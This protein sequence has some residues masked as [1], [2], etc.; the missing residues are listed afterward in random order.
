[1]SANVEQ[2]VAHLSASQGRLMAYIFSLV[3]KLQDAQDVFQQTSLVL[4]RKYDQF[5]SS[6]DFLTWACGVASY[7]V[8]NYQRAASRDR[9][10]FNDALLQTLADER[11]AGET[12]SQQR[13]LALE[14]CVKR[15]RA[16][17]RELIEKA[18]SGQ[19]ALP[20]LA[21]EMGRAVQTIYN[22]LNLIRCKLVECVD[23]SSAEQGVAS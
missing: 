21:A 19:R 1:V 14:E 20:E 16:T 23:R 10:C 13:D 17:D 18:Y 12:R 15:L 6:R 8:R 22:R 3:P 2:F 9:H 5:D 4:W 7:E 11:L